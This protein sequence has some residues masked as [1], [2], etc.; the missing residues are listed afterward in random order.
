MLSYILIFAY[1]DKGR[2]Q[3][4]FPVESLEFLIDLILPA[5]LWPWDRFSL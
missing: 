5:S 2:S 3:V 1:S 4:P